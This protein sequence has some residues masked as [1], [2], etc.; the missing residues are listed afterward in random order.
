MDSDS[1]DG[2]SPGFWFYPGDFER[3][4]TMASLAA[5]GICIRILGWMHHNEAH[6]GFLELPTGDAMTIKHI[7]LRAGKPLKQVTALVSELRSLG[8]FSE[9]PTGTLYSRRMARETHISEVRS[10]AA[11]SRANKAQR[12]VNGTFKPDTGT[13]FAGSIAGVLVEDLH[14][15]NIQALPT[16]A[17]SDSDSASVLLTHTPVRAADMAPGSSQ[18]FW[19]FW[20]LYPRKQRRDFAA[21]QFLSLVT[22]DNEAAVFECLQRYLHSDEVR[23]GVITNP[24]KWLYEQYRN[25]WVGDWPAAAGVNSTRQASIDAEWGAL[26][27]GS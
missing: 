14:Q 21:A 17:V 8:V 1:K 7:A 3:D 11:K 13:E 9:T 18:R 6:R 16:V 10:A 23:R 19:E 5:Q 4:L 25:G 20:E 24:D 27:N 15:Q 22:V 12:A 26:A 2:K